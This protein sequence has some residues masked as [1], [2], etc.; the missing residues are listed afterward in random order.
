L[1]LREE[2]Q[3][4]EEDDADPFQSSG[5][6]DGGHGVAVEDGRKLELFPLGWFYRE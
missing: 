5:G 6:V 4:E 3:E 2:V 1:L